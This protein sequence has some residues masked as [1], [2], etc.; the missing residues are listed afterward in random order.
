MYIQFI[1][2]S[3]KNISSVKEVI[4]FIEKNKLY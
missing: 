4:K 1:Q 2:L 3:V